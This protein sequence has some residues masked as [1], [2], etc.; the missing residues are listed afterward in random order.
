M[1]AVIDCGTTTTR[2]YIVGDNEAIIASGRESIGVR[3]TSITG[4]REKLRTGIIELFFEVL[5]EGNIPKDNIQFAIASGMITSEIGLIE[6]PHLIAP[7]GLKEIAENIVEV[8]DP[9][10]LPL[11]CPICFVRGVR[12]E[13]APNA[14]AQDLREIDFMRGEEVQCIGIL[15]SIKPKCPCSIVTLSSH[16]KVIYIDKDQRIL[17]S[18]TTI[19]GQFYNA[20]LSA[21]NLG[22]SLVTNEGEESGGYL[23]KELITVAKDCVKFAGLGRTC[24]MAR[25]MQVL[26]KTNAAERRTFISA[27]IAADDMK[28]FREMRE[29]GFASD[30]YILYG[31][32]PRCDLYAY[33]IR[34]EFGE[35]LH[36]KTIWD[37]E[38]IDELTV[39]GTI[40][41]AGDYIRQ[42]QKR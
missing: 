42:K 38:K 2:I 41:V 26:L 25:F 35:N 10:I 17:K 3:D 31:Q 18:N 37:S 24:L 34:E 19:S 13:Y 29:R 28:A 22:K 40:A 27:A 30:R 12:N 36:I 23:E 14:R 6:I 7:I 11:G 39:K 32:Q 33:M 1:Y 16:T 5:R 15:G 21:T 20:L 9:D 8:N 4:S